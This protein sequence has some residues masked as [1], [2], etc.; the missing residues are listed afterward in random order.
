VARPATRGAA[1]VVP[2]EPA[3]VVVPAA[4]LGRRLG[5]QGPKALIP[6]AGR[7]LLAWVLADLEASASAG[8]VVVATHPTAIARV[9]ALVEGADGRPFAKVHAVVAGGATRQQSVAAGL[10]ALPPGWRFV[11]VHDAARP[12]AGPA[13]LDRLL[14]L[15]REDPDGVAGVVPGAPVTDTI[16]E[17][18]AAGRSKGVVDRDRLRGMQTPQVF[19]RTALERAHAL[20]A[21]EGV[22]AT[23]E[24]ALVE[25][26]GWS[27]LVAPGPAENLKVTT[28]LDLAV[29]EAILAGRE[30][31][32]A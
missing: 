29:A 9:R 13:L 7:P 3:G 12:L 18:D 4:G 27:V 25:R 8:P 15:L 1:P 14:A 17:V 21:D 31:P 16:R 24:A 11:A 20:A 2:A 23:D 10:A 19:L 6:L 28:R 30:R 5:D 26:A 22:E 32:D